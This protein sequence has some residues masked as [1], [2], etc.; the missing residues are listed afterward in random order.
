MAYLGIDLGNKMCGLAWS[1]DGDFVFPLPQVARISLMGELK[2]IVKEK[3]IDCIVL[4]LPYDLYGKDLKQLEKTKVFQE[5]LK[6]IFS[7]IQ[8]AGMDE[9]F[10]TFQSLHALQG[11]KNFAQKKDSLSAYFILE[12][13]LQQKKWN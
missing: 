3:N 8:I 6:N 11:D 10:T 2:K 5:K 12:S 1:L 4:W 7:D 13:Y 9:R